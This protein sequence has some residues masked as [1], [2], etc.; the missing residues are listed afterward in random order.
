VLS[1]E[2]SDIPSKNYVSGFPAHYSVLPEKSVSADGP[3]LAISGGKCIISGGCFEL[4]SADIPG[5]EIARSLERNLLARSQCPIWRHTPQEGTMKKQLITAAALLLLAP[6]TASADLLGTGNLTITASNPVIG[7]Y[8][9]DYDASNYVHT[10]GLT[11]EFA[12]W[13]VFCISE[14]EIIS[15]SSPE[16]GFYAASEKLANAALITWIANWANIESDNDINKGFAQG[17]IWQSLGVIGGTDYLD[18][19]TNPTSGLFA[20]ASDAE[21][22]AYVNQWLVAVNPTDGGVETGGVQDY[23]VKAAPV[24][25]PATMLLFGTGLASLAAVARRRRN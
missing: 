1:I 9:G 19:F 14:E 17:A 3:S 24:P 23:L 2:Q 16:F 6:L 11:I 15:G 8:Y 22:G 7:G 10:D 25:E 13:D 18:F 21:K 5:P 20:K 12:D 4:F